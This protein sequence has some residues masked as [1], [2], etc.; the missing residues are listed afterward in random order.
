MASVVARSEHVR[1]S[2]HAGNE[3]LVFAPAVPLVEVIKNDHI[4]TSVLVEVL[5]LFDPEG[6]G[7][8]NA[9]SSRFS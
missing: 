8:S 5:G 6:I 7:K 3:A 1:V 2:D 4:L 9:A